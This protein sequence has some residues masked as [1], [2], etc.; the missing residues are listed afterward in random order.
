MLSYVLGLVTALLVAVPTIIFILANLEKAEKLVALFWKALSLLRGV[1]KGAHKQYV[2]HDLQGRVNDFAKNLGK[3][4][5]Y[6]AEERVTL[7]W[8]DDGPIARPSY[9]T[10]KSYLGSDAMTRTMLASSTVHTC[11]FPPASWRNSRGIRRPAK[12]SPSTFTSRPS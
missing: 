1:F 10:V 9:R 6:L 12:L 11:S 3:E 5:P 8:I 7:E 2:K 4:A